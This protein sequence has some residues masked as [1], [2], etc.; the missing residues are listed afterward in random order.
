MANHYILRVYLHLLCIKNSHIGGSYA[1]IGSKR[2]LYEWTTLFFNTY[3][4][5][6]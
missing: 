6:E 3:A 2:I 5:N 4:R 1:F